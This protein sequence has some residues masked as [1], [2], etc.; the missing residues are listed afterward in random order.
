MSIWTRTFWKDA[1]ERAISTAAQ[2]AVAVL[3]VAGL[4]L[5]DVDWKDTA[6]V[7]GLAG[8]LAVLKALAAT[9]VGD[10]SASLVGTSNGPIYVGAAT[11][12]EV[13]LIDTDNEPDDD[14]GPGEHKRVR[15]EGGYLSISVASSRF[16]LMNPPTSGSPG[17]RFWFSNRS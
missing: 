3:G 14:L 12:P 1:A 9:Y 17:V 5:L 15:D 13:D 10:G 8:L 6:S 11:D 7:A 4:G 2:S 16:F